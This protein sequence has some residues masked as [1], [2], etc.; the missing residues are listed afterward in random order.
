MM[1]LFLIGFI[2]KS[3]IQ[4]QETIVEKEVEAKLNEA[5]LS[6]NLAFVSSTVTDEFITKQRHQVE[7]LAKGPKK[8]IFM[9]QLEDI[10]T[11]HSISK[12]INLFFEKDFLIGDQIDNTVKLRKSVSY[13]EI[14]RT[15]KEI[16]NQNK[17]IDPFYKVIKKALKMAGNRAQLR[18]EV[19]PVKLNVPVI[20]QLPELPTGCE[21]TAVTMML[22]YAGSH[23]NKI[24][25][26]REMPKHETNPKMGYVGDPF[27]R[28][29]WTIYP[30]A[31]T[32]LIESEVGSSEDLSGST[33]QVIENKLAQEDPVVVWMTMHG[34]VVHAITLVG[35]DNNYIFY[36]DPWT[37]LGYLKMEKSEFLENW[38]SQ[39]S[40]AV[41]I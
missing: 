38:S 19:V 32:T 22:Q 5:Y 20:G 40:R 6:T 25:V 12:K 11:R 36:N 1:S 33:L 9:K 7:K 15:E 29:G 21:V 28:S 14:L 23:Q 24:Q 2:W 37:G 16:F 34:F 31:L 18:D 13:E 8:N 3:H 17:Q 35:F 39:E 30:P 41:S 4:K 10:T 27:S 26:A